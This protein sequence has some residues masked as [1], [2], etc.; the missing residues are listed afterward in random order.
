MCLN[1][2]EIIHV[3]CYLQVDVIGFSSSIKN[4]DVLRKEEGEFLVFC[5]QYHHT[6]FNNFIIYCVVLL[7]INLV[8]KKNDTQMRKRR[9]GICE[10]FSKLFHLIVCLY[11]N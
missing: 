3:K 8:N 6:N 11:V 10:I 7:D 1:G 2:N 5:K 9:L 4:A